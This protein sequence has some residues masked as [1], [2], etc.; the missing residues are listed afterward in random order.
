M[1]KNIISVCLL[2]GAAAILP[3]C[4]SD[5]SETYALQLGDTEFTIEIARTPQE[6]QVGLMNR[7]SMPENHGMLF[8]FQRDQVLG[9]WMRNTHI[10]LS[11]AYI[12]R[13]GCIREI[14]DMQP[15]SE[16][17]VQSSLPVRYALEVHQGAFSRVGIQVGDCL[18]LAELLQ[19]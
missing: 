13:N 14:H 6:R 19:P 16:R 1:I 8:V 11:I 9:F 2:V 3:A 10:P 7:T 4:T 18:D 17:V 12:D 15:L 5:E